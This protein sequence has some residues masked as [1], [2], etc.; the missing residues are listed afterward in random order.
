MCEIKIGT[1]V[2]R[3]IDFSPIEYYNVNVVNIN[4]KQTW[5]LGRRETQKEQR[6]LSCYLQIKI[7]NSEILSTSIKILVTPL[8]THKRLREIL[9]LL[10]WAQMLYQSFTPY[11]LDDCFGNGLCCYACK[12]SIRIV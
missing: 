9:S 10:R 7:C 3:V 11:D 4:L 1:F 12:V 6:C 2:I 8:R 5:M